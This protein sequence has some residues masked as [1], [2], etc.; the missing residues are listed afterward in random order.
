[1][2][3]KDLRARMEITNRDGDIVAAVG[4]TCDRVDPGSLGWLLDQG[5]IAPATEPVAAADTDAPAP[6]AADKEGA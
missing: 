6:D 4:E 5:F 3:G 1:M 2:N